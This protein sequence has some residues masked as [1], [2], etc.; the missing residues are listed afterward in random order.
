MS[1]KK[2]SIEAI[3]HQLSFY[4]Q[5]R[6]ELF[7]SLSEAERS[8]VL[9]KLSTHLQSEL[10][11][12]LSNQEVVDTIEHLDPDEIV[13]MLQRMS[14]KRR[15]TITHELSKVLQQD[16]AALSK[17]DPQT[18]AGLMTMDYIWVDVADTIAAVVDQ[19]RTHETRT[20]RVPVITVTKAGTVAGYLPGH[21][22]GVAESNEKVET[23]LRKLLTIK[24]NQSHQAVFRL[25]KE[26]PHSKVA[27]IGK[28][29]NVLGIIYSDDVLQLLDDQSTVS[30]YS[31]AG[32]SHEETVTDT[33]KTK[34]RARYKWLM[35]N[36]CTA[37]LAA[38]VVGLF[39][40]TISKFVLLAVYMPIVAGMGGNAGT[41]T[42]AVMV[43][44][45]SRKQ[46]DLATGAQAIKR[47]VLAGLTNGLIN[48]AI[49][50]II[51]L[52]LNKDPRLAVVLGAAMVAALTVSG[53]FG[54]LVPLVMQKLGKDP[55]TS[56]TIFITTATDVF[57]FLAFLGLAS[58]VLR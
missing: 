49:V 40:E 21:I 28:N 22:L 47:E 50:A 26:H 55:A 30:L 16:I 43:R 37:F 51:V 58:V 8:S 5:Q 39:E 34:V 44:G 20:G 10:L 27:V 56:A 54:S 17:F 7:L 45:I 13:D 9:L 42:L 31:F 48:G 23:H 32:V 24:H 57:G 1:S 2:S 36:L 11:K 29:G 15:N 46:V 14:D 25:F 38:S 4:P 33:V 52:V 18:A 19:L 12:E 41:Q 3:L 6:K 53:F 35:L